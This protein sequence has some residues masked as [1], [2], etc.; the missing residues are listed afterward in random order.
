MWKKCMGLIA[1]MSMVAG[2]ATQF[3]G[4]P[5]IEDGRAGCEVKCRG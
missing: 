1:L 3:T 2:C 4:D 5:H